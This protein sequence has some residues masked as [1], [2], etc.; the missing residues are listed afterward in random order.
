M[1]YTVFPFAAWVE[2]IGGGREQ[3]CMAIKQAAVKLYWC[4]TADHDEDWFIFAESA[5]QA[6]AY[7]EHYEGYGKGDASSRLI[8]SNVTLTELVGGKPP[9]HA[10]MPDL[11]QLGF[12]DAGTEPN[13]RRVQ[14]NGELFEEG[15]PESIVDTRPEN[16]GVLPA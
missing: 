9:C 8:I 7:H 6:R 4:T 12:A 13:L 11:L 5:R 1:C 14:L 16:P 2:S 10:Q 3:A 15:I